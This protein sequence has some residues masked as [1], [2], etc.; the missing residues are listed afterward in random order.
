MPGQRPPGRL[1]PVA[2]RPVAGVIIAVCVAILAALAGLVYHG[3]QPTGLDSAVARVLVPSSGP[4]GFHGGPGSPR[5]AFELAA[6]GQV[7]GPIPITFLTCVL[8]YCCI[9]MRRFRGAVLTAA[10]V[11]IASSLTEFVLKPLIHRTFTGFLSFPSGHTTAAFALAGS[12]VVLLAGP[13]DTRLPVSL[14][15]VLAALTLGAGALVAIGL[16]VGRQHYFTDTI[17]GAA[18]G[19]GVALSAALV[20]DKVAERRG[21]AAQLIAPEPATAQQGAAGRGLLVCSNSWL[22]N[23]ALPWP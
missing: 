4:G 7:G 22:G 10:A 9:A 13:P 16:V 6:I 11:I 1:I 2:L 23:G 21:R 3:S 19:I 18:V 15:A 8:V 20:I 12:I 17:G 5:L 14:R